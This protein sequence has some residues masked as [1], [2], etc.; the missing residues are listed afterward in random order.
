MA[1]ALGLDLVAFGLVSVAS[2]PVFLLVGRKG[3][4]PQIGSDPMI[5]LKHMSGSFGGHPRG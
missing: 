5:T 1:V 2:G 4:D 3:T